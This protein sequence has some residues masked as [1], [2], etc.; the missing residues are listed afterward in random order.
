LEIAG[1]GSKVVRDD[2]ENVVEGARGLRTDGL[3]RDGMTENEDEMGG[4]GI[5]RDVWRPRDKLL[6]VE[7]GNAA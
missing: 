5:P 6:S 1:Y 2:D 3:R 7:C 4:D